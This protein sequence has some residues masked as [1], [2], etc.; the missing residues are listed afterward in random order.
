[1]IPPYER[2]P[3]RLVSPPQRRPHKLVNHP[4]GVVQHK[5]IVRWAWV[6]NPLLLTGVLG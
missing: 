5:T 1:M 3:N 4:H 2:R 6:I